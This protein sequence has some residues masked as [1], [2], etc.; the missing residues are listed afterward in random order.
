MQHGSRDCLS[1]VLCPAREAASCLQSSH[2]LLSQMAARKSRAEAPEQDNG[3]QH[4]S[5]AQ[6]L[7]LPL[8]CNFRLR[9]TVHFHVAC[10]LEVQALACLQ[11]SVLRGRPGF[12]DDIAALV[13]G[14]RD[15]QERLSEVR[16]LQPNHAPLPLPN[17]QPDT[18][19]R[20]PPH[21]AQRRRAPCDGPATPALPSCAC[22][23]SPL[24]SIN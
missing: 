17:L 15:N 10:T 6:S 12:E 22:A 16:S 4:A 11:A 19:E 8:Q 20:L 13:A 23:P 5:S 3:A 18:A 2:I 7:P 21:T 1:A 14:S 9:Y 24:W